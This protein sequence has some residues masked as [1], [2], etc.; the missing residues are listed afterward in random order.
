MQAKITKIVGLITLFLALLSG[1]SKA[2][3]YHHYAKATNYDMTIGLPQR[4]DVTDAKVADLTK[5]LDAAGAHIISVGQEYRIILPADHI[6]YYQS[7][8]LRWDAYDLVNLAVDYLK[9]YQKVSVRVS[10]FTRDKDK[11]F[12]GALSYAR[13]R[14][15]SDYLWSQDIDSRLLYTQVHSMKE[16]ENCCGGISH[17]NSDLNENIEISFRNTII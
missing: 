7:P 4:T 3:K 14:S 12:A 16:D 6:F 1:C 9:Q 11:Q 5:R 2:G 13:A 17:R 10:A 15:I 8:R